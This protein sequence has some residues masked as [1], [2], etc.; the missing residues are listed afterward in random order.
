MVSS[1]TVQELG[2]N[3]FLQHIQ[4]L[5]LRLLNH[6]FFIVSAHLLHLALYIG[7]AHIGGHDDDGILEVYPR[8]P[9]YRSGGH[10]RV[11]AT[12]C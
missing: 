6:L 3:G 7:T 5:F 8:V 12:R 2:A 1:H 9:Y 11:P 10:R 4:H